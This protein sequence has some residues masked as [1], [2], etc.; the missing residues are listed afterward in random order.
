MSRPFT[1]FLNNQQ[2]GQIHRPPKTPRLSP[3]RSFSRFELGLVSTLTMTVATF[4]L[5]VFG[6]LA[7]DLILDFEVDRWQIGFLVTAM[8]FTAGLISPAIGGVTDRWG[9]MRAT[10]VVFLMG[11]VGL[12]L[13]ALSPN[14]LVLTAVA[15]FSGL[16]HALSNPASNMLIFDNVESGSRGVIT[17]VKQSGVQVGAF[18]SGALLPLFAGWWGW[19]GSLLPFLAIPL[20]GLGGLV[21]RSS[22][23]VAHHETK[24]RKQPVPVA[25]RWVAVYGAITGLAM[26]A[27]LTFV[28][29]FLQETQGWTLGE[30]GWLLAGIGLL[31]IVSRISWGH[32]AERTM[33]HGSILR[34]LAITSTASAGLLA[35]GAVEQVAV[36]MMI[37]V[38]FLFA[39]GAV[40]WNAVGMLAVM[41]MSPAGGLGRGTGAVLLGFLLGLGAGAPLMGASVDATGS[42]LPGWIVVAVLFAT[43]VFT[44]TKISQ[45]STLARS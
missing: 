43:G 44:A 36:W 39:F 26:S 16:P 21:R 7:A 41:E 15:V 12:A 14:Y 38:A 28:P 8:G 4:P 29:L 33:S 37:A 9:G 32:V 2:G 25:V 18:L 17:G 10:R 1:T 42:Y 35:W 27:V 24:G 20:I 5:N 13:T 3:M 34:L 11:L 40:A 6:V 31:G 45:T 19:R 22:P 30:A 23:H